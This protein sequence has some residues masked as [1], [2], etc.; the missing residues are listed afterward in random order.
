MDDMTKETR[1]FTTA[2]KVWWI[3]PARCGHSIKCVFN[4]VKGLGFD[5]YELTVITGENGRR[6]TTSCSQSC[7]EHSYN[8]QGP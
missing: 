6:L 7:S 2:R 3:D 1:A 5:D 8:V 4:C